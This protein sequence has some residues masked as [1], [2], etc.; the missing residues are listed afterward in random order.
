MNKDGWKD[1]LTAWSN[2]KENGGE[3]V[4]FEHPE[5]GLNAGYWK[6]HVIHSGPDV[7]FEVVTNLPGYENS[8]IIFAAEFFN[9]RVTVYEIQNAEVV[10]YRILDTTIDQAYSV[11]YLDINEDGKYE[12]LVNNH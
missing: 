12:L 3:L 2:A 4:W 5:G 8:L 6:E 7:I 9:K 11:R 1:Y 10:N